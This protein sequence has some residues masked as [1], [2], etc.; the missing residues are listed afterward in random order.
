MVKIKPHFTTGQAKDAH[1]TQVE[2][3]L[4]QIER[5]EVVLKSAYSVKKHIFV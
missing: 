1:R 2:L 5:D 3:L 4:Y